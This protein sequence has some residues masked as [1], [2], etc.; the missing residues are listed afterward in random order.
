M[1]TK[2]KAVVKKEEEEPAQVA[3][4]ATAPAPAPEPAPKVVEAATTSLKEPGEK[5]K[6]IEKVAVEVKDEPIS[7]NSALY[8]FYLLY[9]TNFVT[10]L[11]LRHILRVIKEEAP[12]NLAEYLVK[13][14]A[15]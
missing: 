9:K 11:Q 5:I 8:V 15:K 4:P 13:E 3:V 7:A 1:A 14:A 6:H 10:R 12:E 2:K